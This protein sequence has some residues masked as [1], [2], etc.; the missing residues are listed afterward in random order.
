[1]PHVPELPRRGLTIDETLRK[2]IDAQRTQRLAVTRAAASQKLPGIDLGESFEALVPRLSDQQLKTELGEDT[3]VELVRANPS[4]AYSEKQPL[5]DNLRLQVKDGHLVPERDRQVGALWDAINYLQ[6]AYKRAESTGILNYVF[7][8]SSLK[9]VETALD[10]YTKHINTPLAELVLEVPARLLPGSQEVEQLVDKNVQAGMNP[11]EARIDAFQRSTL[12]GWVKQAVLFAADPATVLPFLKASSSLAKGVGSGFQAARAARAKGTISA[13]KEPAKLSDVERLLPTD[14]GPAKMPVLEG[15]RKAM[16]TTFSPAQLAAPKSIERALFTRR[17]ADVVADQMADLSLTVLS[18]NGSAA[19]VFGAYKKTG[20]SFYRVKRLGDTPVD[21]IISN[22]SPWLSSMTDA[23][24]MYV[25]EY[26]SLTKEAYGYLLAN[27][28]SVNDATLATDVLNYAPRFVV[29]QSSAQLLAK[30]GKMVGARPGSFKE[31]LFDS[32]AEGVAAGEDYFST[33]YA[34]NRYLRSVFQHVYD[35]QF[36]RKLTAEG[37]IVGGQPKESILASVAG[38]AASRRLPGYS[39]VGND[40]LE[41]ARKFEKTFAN[42]KVL[43]DATTLLQQASKFNALV[44]TT[45][46][47]TDLG[48]IFVQ[49]LPTLFYK[50]E[51]WSRNLVTLFDAL[52]TPGM[53]PRYIAS[54]ADSAADFINRGGVFGGTEFLEAMERGGWLAKI[55]SVSILGKTVDRFQSSFQTYLDM[56][57]L[58]MWQALKPLAKGNA[59]AETQVAKFVNNMWGRFSSQQL[60]VPMS[61]RQL[62]SS[63][64]FFAPQYTKAQAALLLA[65]GRGDIRG[66]F[67]RKAVASLFLG[68]AWLHYAAS[69]AS[70]QKVNFDPRDPDFMKTEV[71]GLDVGF[72]GKAR[73]FLRLAAN[74][75]KESYE[76]PLGVVTFN[77]LGENNDLYSHPLVQWARSQSAP[78][79]ELVTRLLSGID[80][81]GRVMPG[82]TED[83]LAWSREI[84]DQFLPIWL[85]AA[86]ERGQ[87]NPQALPFEFFGLATSP[88]TASEE[89]DSAYNKAAKE[90]FSVDDWR[91]LSQDQVL[92]LRSHHPEL[93]KLDQAVDKQQRD[94]R[95]NQERFQVEDALDKL[96]EERLRRENEAASLFQEGTLDARGFRERLSDAASSTRDARHGIEVAHQEYFDDLERNSQKRRQTAREEGKLFNLALSDYV[97]AFGESETSGTLDYGKLDKRMKALSGVYG[98]EML[99]RV[100]Q[101][102]SD[103][104]APGLHPLAQLYYDSLTLLR[105]YFE[106]YKKVLSPELQQDWERYVQFAPNGLRDALRDHPVIGQKIRI[107]EERVK[108]EQLRMRQKDKAMDRALVLFFGRVPK[109]PANARR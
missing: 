2:E 39:F 77:R 86:Y 41:N 62:E 25:Q 12:P 108:S 70:G 1:M 3:D 79:A 59:D 97:A 11:Y 87:F 95:R 51:I 6:S 88:K 89:R 21:D 91:K 42:A 76:N 100:K 8:L 66:E 84:G 103:K 55:T 37:W 96:F 69:K 72:G 78:T 35:K 109:H 18:R 16:L 63:L 104:R 44:R 102:L 53:L 5:A 101:Y 92:S 64:L 48:A 56:G 32:L 47:V 13:F 90:V 29:K 74:V 24:K 68:Q 105:P 81:I 94:F 9:D 60:G 4:K 10:L 82:V 26:G 28:V 50:P 40:A 14:S 15:I 75:A 34:L 49:G 61:L 83:P 80:P 71:L 45:R 27:G 38:P 67:A 73:S 107:M 85:T 43:G 54:N 99:A 20:E 106:A 46:T 98:D 22:P 30:T 52:R 33:E 23:E 36:V 57:S 7:P 65:I 19:T 17:A 93:E 58:S 31:R